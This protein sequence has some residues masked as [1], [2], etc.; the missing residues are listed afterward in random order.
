M[1][2]VKI[3]FEYI[4]LEASIYLKYITPHLLLKI[5]KML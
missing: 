2:C 5:V 4:S 1:S 3:F